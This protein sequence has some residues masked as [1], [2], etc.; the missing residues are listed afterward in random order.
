MKS[1]HYNGLLMKNL[2]RF[3]TDAPLWAAVLALLISICVA[4]WVFNLK[5]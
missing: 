1:G 4:R 2:K 5:M 3:K